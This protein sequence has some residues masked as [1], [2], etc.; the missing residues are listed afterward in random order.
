MQ[1]EKLVIVR[2][3]IRENWMKT[4]PSCLGCDFIYNISAG[5]KK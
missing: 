2:E 5:Y 1:E 4:V 3:L